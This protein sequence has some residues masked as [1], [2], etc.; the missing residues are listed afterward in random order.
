MPGMFETEPG[1][2]FAANTCRLPGNQW[3]RA[4]LGGAETLAG[5]VN[6]PGVLAAYRDLLARL[7]GDAYTDFLL[8]FLDKG[9]AAFGDDWRYADICTALLGLSRRLDIRDY[10]E[11]GVR[12][13]RSMAMVAASRPQVSIVGFD[14]WKEGYAGMPNPGPDYVRGVMSGLGHQGPLELVG[15]D[16]RQTVPA[17]FAAHPDAFFDCITVDGDH[18]EEGAVADLLAVLPRLRVGGVLV[19]DDIAHP[20][21]PHLGRVWDRVVARRPAFT[22]YAFKELGYGVALAVRAYADDVPNRGPDAGQRFP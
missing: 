7:E 14:L 1:P 4:V 22:S 17:Y 13:G 18:S 5:V 11:I 19:F 15:G 3:Y 2:F 16:S 12:R 20:E 6:Q 10:L 21:L 8:A 9:L